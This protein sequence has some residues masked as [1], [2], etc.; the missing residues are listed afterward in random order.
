MRREVVKLFRFL[1]SRHNPT[2]TC[3][4]AQNCTFRDDTGT[5]YTCCRR[6]EVVKL[7]RFPLSQHN[8][9]GTCN[10]SQNCTFRD[11]TGTFYTCCR[12][13]DAAKLFIVLVKSVDFIFPLLPQPFGSLHRWGDR[14]IAKCLPTYVNTETWPCSN[15]RAFHRSMT[16]RAL[17]QYKDINLACSLGCIFFII[18]E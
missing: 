3:N 6:R 16:G 15:T 18:E 12:H 7:F 1:L 10:N 2:R 14:L 4:N 8:P 9:K 11:D 17:R 13:W 5:F